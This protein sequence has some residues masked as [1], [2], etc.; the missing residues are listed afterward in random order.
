MCATTDAEQ[1]LN[2]LETEFRS[3]HERLRF[4][5]DLEDIQGLVAQADAVLADA[6]ILCSVFNI[7]QPPW[8]QAA[9]RA[10]GR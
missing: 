6:R 3:I 5:F 9:K 7:A 1:R 10:G 4:A 2:Q 8:M